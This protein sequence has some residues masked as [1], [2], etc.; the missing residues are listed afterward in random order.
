MKSPITHGHG[1]GHVLP[2][3]DGVVAR[4]GGPSIC[5]VCAKEKAA[6]ESERTAFVD[7]VMTDDKRFFVAEDFDSLVGFMYA[8][9]CANFANAKVMPLLEEN[10]KL[11]AQL[12]A[13]HLLGSVERRCGS[14]SH[15]SG[16]TDAQ[17]V[18]EWCRAFLAKMEGDAK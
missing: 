4:C 8:P 13:L 2:R 5:T 12:A 9:Y 18:A 7:A 1:H 3:L 10:A 16:Y 17:E 15:A 11:K 14:A 6:W